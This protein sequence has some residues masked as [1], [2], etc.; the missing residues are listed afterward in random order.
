[1]T[2]GKGAFCAVQ[3]AGPRLTTLPPTLS[4]SPT[5]PSLEA[6]SPVVTMTGL[7]RAP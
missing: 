2:A 6:P 4:P 1:L 3:P 5:S 7:V